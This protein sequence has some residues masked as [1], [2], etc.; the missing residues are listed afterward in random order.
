MT[1]CHVTHMV[2]LPSNIC[3]VMNWSLF[4][5]DDQDGNK[6]GSQMIVFSF[7]F[8]I[9]FCFF[10]F[11]SISFYFSLFL[12]ISF[13]L[14]VCLSISF[15]VCLSVCLS[16]FWLIGWEQ[17]RDGFTRPF[18]TW[19]PGSSFLAFISH[20]ESRTNR[21]FPRAEHALPAGRTCSAP[22][23][24][25]LFPW[26]EHKMTVLPAGR[27]CSARGPNTFLLR[28]EHV[29]P[30]GRTWWNRGPNMMKP[31]ASQ[32]RPMGRKIGSRAEKSAHGQIFGPSV[33]GH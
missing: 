11:L 19:F 32:N 7:Y 6:C 10:L 4:I 1:H 15:Y 29:L 14:Y 23:P 3:H 5:L 8:S 22:G 20:T 31:R 27:T 21:F 9:S 24:N 16:F 17:N 2:S 13:Y 12:S 18:V 26:A 28:A 30:A 25:M 33:H